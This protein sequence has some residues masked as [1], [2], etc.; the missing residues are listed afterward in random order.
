[1]LHFTTSVLFFCADSLDAV[2]G[3][4]VHVQIKTYCMS[5]IINPRRGAEHLHKCYGSVIASYEFEQFSQLTR[6]TVVQ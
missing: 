6:D 3:A 2:I 4:Q 1:M 5:P